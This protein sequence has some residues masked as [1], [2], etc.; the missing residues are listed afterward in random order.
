M[1]SGQAEFSGDGF[2]TILT[3]TRQ[4]CSDHAPLV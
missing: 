2:Q 3:G 4:G 1:D